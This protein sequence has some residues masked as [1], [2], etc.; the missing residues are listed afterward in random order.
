MSI[1]VSF[2][3]IDV[4]IQTFADILSKG[5]STFTSQ[6][7]CA[8]NYRVVPL[9]TQCLLHAGQRQSDILSLVSYTVTVCGICP[10]GWTCKGAVGTIIGKT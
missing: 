7:S 10:A 2:H 1:F 3:L 8:L 9:K 5:S 4:F 6:P